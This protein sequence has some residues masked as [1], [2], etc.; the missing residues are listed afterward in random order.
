MN[1][2]ERPIVSVRQRAAAINRTVIE[3]QQRSR[4]TI[5]KAG[6]G[7]IA[8][9]KPWR[10]VGTN[11]NTTTLS[12]R[13]VLPPSSTTL[14]S[15]H[16]KLDL[17]NDTV[18]KRRASNINNNTNASTTSSRLSYRPMTT[19][20]TATTSRLPQRRT[21]A[22]TT[23][24]QVNHPLRLGK[25][26]LSNNERDELVYTMKQRKMTMHEN[27]PQQPSRHRVQIERSSLK[28]SR[29][30][31]YQT[32]PRQRPSS[33]A[34]TSTTNS[35][36]STSLHPVLHDDTIANTYTKYI[37]WQFV[38]LDADESID[39]QKMEEENRLW[40][41]Y[42]I[43]WEL[44]QHYHH[45]QEEGEDDTKD[46]IISMIDDRL[47]EFSYM[48]EQLQDTVQG[49]GA[50]TL[51]L[52]DSLIQNLLTLLQ[53]VRTYTR[54]LLNKM[55]GVMMESKLD[56]LETDIHA[57]QECQRIMNSVAQVEAENQS[58]SALL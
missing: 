46:P 52:S 24:A 56:E 43:L 20:T 36:V 31:H 12:R 10:S 8:V 58:L 1:E 35:T 15:H 34:S 22:T 30:S 14:R 11:A 19:V 53:E 54:D 5:K 50:G 4:H 42:D 40:A 28:G 3:E 17:H 37:Q 7:L 18:E 55:D 29:H 27:Q 6:S 41:M 33:I 47:K 45:H 51:K 16:Q 9:R 39:R 23:T 13:P 49:D 25:R 21:A 57:I 32:T 38:T 44:R 26:E 48:Y 2:E